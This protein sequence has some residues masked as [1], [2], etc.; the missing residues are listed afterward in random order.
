MSRFAL[1]NGRVLADRGIE[2]GL[3]VVVEDGCISAVV[4]EMEALQHTPQ[5]HDLQGA[6][7]LPG[8]IDC[9]VNGGGGV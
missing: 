1:V 5:V 7:L 4:P 3:A 8:Y 6:I 9:Q 2:A